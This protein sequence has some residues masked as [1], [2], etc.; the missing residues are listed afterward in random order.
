MAEKELIMPF[1]FVTGGEGIKGGIADVLMGKGAR[2]YFEIMETG[3]RHTL[4]STPE[5]LK[6]SKTAEFPQREVLGMGTQEQ[7]Y[8]YTNNAE[9]SFDVHISATPRLPT[10]KRSIKDVAEE[11]N[12]LSKVLHP[13]QLT[14]KWGGGNPSKLIFYWPNVVDTIG[15]IHSVEWD[16]RM[17]NK[18]GA[19]TYAIAKITFVADYGE[20]VMQEDYGK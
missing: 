15:F 6:V 19:I 9:F 4:Y 17:F 1:D 20:N 13:R 8:A 7:D 11:M 2:V 14:P 3:E 12:F 10:E 18:Q 5:S 16:V